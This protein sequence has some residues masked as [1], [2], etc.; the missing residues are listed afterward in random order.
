MLPA[1]LQNWG[2]Q[3][4]G[5]SLRH[6]ETEGSQ[7]LEAAISGRTAASLFAAMTLPITNSHWRGKRT[8]FEVV[9]TRVTI[10]EI[11]Y[12]GVDGSVSSTVPHWQFLVDFEPLPDNKKKTR[13]PA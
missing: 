12:M 8:P 3:A 10:R 4:F 13:R 9:V 1:S 2:K 11:S 5:S 7:A 6:F